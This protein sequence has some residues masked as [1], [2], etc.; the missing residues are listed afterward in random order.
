MVRAAGVGDRRVGLLLHRT[1]FVVE[2]GHLQLD[3]SRSFSPA[4]VPGELRGAAPGIASRPSGH[5]WN[6]AGH[7]TVACAPDRGWPLFGD[8]LCGQHDRSGRR[9]FGG[10]VSDNPGAWIPKNRSVVWLYQ[11]FLRARRLSDR[12][13]SA[14]GIDGE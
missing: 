5:G 6:S 11:S 9:G 10:D 3:R 14:E 4:P 1:D 8:A 7:G 12:L 13:V 2:S